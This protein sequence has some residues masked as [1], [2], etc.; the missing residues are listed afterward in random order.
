MATYT[1]KEAKPA[2]SANKGVV[3]WLRENLFSDV[4][5]SLLTLFGLYILYAL[6]PPLLNWAIFDATWSGT[7]AELPSDGGARWIFIVE[8]F[9]QFIYGFYPESLHWRPNLV[10]FLSVALLVSLK[11]LK[12]IK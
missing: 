12:T 7:K 11:F 5:N 1:M 3:F 8:K 10:A 4:K 9:D 6:I 2:P